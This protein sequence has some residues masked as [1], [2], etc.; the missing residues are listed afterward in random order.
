MDARVE[1]T[2]ERL[3]DGRQAPSGVLFSLGYFSFTPGV[4]PTPFGPA[5][6]FAHAPACAW[7]SKREV[8]RA[9]Q[10]H[11]SFLLSIGR[12]DDEVRFRPSPE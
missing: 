2:Q 5:S 12:Y 7:T 11:E 10:E 1:A 3:P 4:L 9:P 6:L 8:T